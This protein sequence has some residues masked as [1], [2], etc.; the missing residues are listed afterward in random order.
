MASTGSDPQPDHHFLNEVANRKEKQHYPE[1]TPAVLAARLSVGGNG[2]RVVIGFHHDQ[3]WAKYH[4]KR[5]YIAHPGASHFVPARRCVELI[6]GDLV[7]IIVHGRS[8]HSSDGSTIRS[9]PA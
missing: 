4:E 9:S 2:A 1:Q 3:S 8:F 7:R 6:G 5:E